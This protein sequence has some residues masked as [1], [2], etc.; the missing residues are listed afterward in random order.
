MTVEQSF[1]QT[2]AVCTTLVAVIRD[3]FFLTLYCVIIPVF[4]SHDS[5]SDCSLQNLTFFWNALL[6]MWQSSDFHQHLI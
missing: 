4:L 3:I 2:L 6:V 1:S 5:S